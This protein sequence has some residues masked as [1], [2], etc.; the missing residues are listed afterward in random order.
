MVPLTVSF[1]M[2]GNKTRAA[3]LKQAY[4]FGFSIIL[5]FAV[6][7][8]LLTVIFGKDAMYVISTHWIPNMIFF[9]IFM[10]FALSFFGLFEITLPSRLV[11]KSDEQADKGGFNGRFLCGIHNRIGF[12]LLYRAHFGCS[13]Y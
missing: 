11:T 13:S 2:K 1:F 6:L 7:G 5:I 9:L 10:T 3:G 8:L 4:F 12:I